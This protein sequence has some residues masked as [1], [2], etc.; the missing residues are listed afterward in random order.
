MSIIR[1]P[2]FQVALLFVSLNT[3]LDSAFA[4]QQLPILQSSSVNQ[5]EMELKTR[6]S[7]EWNERIAPGFWELASQVQVHGELT[8]QP[9]SLFHLQQ[10]LSQL[11][12]EFHARQLASIEERSGR[13]LEILE[14][15]GLTAHPLFAGQVV[16]ASS[17]LV[18]Q[19]V[20]SWVQQGAASE[21]ADTHPLIDLSSRTFAEESVTVNQALHQLPSDQGIHH[22]NQKSAFIEALD[23]FETRI[24][25][26]ETQFLSAESVGEE[27]RGWQIASSFHH[28]P[29]VSWVDP[30]GPL[31]QIPLIGLN[32][33][34]LLESRFGVRSEGT[35]GIVFGRIQAGWKVELSDRAERPIFLD[36][37]G[38]LTDQDHDTV[39]RTFIFLNSAPGVQMVFIESVQGRGNAAVAV[40]VLTGAASY[41]DLTHLQSTTLSGKVTE[42]TEDQSS[43]ATLRVVGQSTAVTGVHLGQEFKL[44][45]VVVAHPYPL[46]VETDRGDGYTQRY[47]L[48]PDQLRDVVLTRFSRERV[49][50]WRGQISLLQGGISPESGMLVAAFPHLVEQQN[51][52]VDLRVRIRP[53]LE[54]TQWNPSVYVRAPNGKLNEGPFIAPHEDFVVGSQIPEGPFILEV[55]DHQQRVLYSEL[56]FASPGV[57]NIF[58]PR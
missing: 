5:D 26:V 11:Q 21:S 47:R 29:T 32:T 15:N 24:D 52:D 28:L 42:R 51:Q 14:W 17:P 37:S 33:I 43:I 13:T 50:R 3:L 34:A 46:F 30:Q 18:A 35:A 16:S 7:R 1:S 39:D 45:G 27:Y 38:L 25:G 2:L 8:A 49:E 19:A 23:R 56:G 36:D 58:N 44:E 57:L 55:V 10:T 54:S 12:F 31:T 53:I 41:L 6:I 4:R 9:E 40:P 20:S 22:E 48:Q